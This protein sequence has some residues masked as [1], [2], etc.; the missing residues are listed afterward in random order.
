MRRTIFEANT[1]SAVQAKRVERL[2]EKAEKLRGLLNYASRAFVVEFA[3]TPKAGKST[4]VE[5]VSHL[6]RR[7]RFRV[8]VLRERAS[9][10]PIPMKGH[11]FFNTWWACTMLAELLENVEA[12]ADIVIKDRGLFDALVW[13]QLQQRR[14][15]VLPDEV[16]RIE[17]FLLLERWKN[18]ID[19]VVLFTV[20][21][22]SAI[23]R[24]IEP[25]I[26]SQVGSVMNPPMLASLNRAARD[27]RK[28]YAGYF[29]EFIPIDT[30]KSTARETGVVLA[31][32]IIDAL[33]RFVNPEILVI[34]RGVADTLSLDGGGCFNRAEVRKAV[35][36]IEANKRFVPRSD[37]ESDERLVQIIPASM[38]VYRGKVFTFQREETD[39]KYHLYGKATIWQGGHVARAKAGTAK[40]DYNS[41]LGDRLKEKL[42][43]S[44]RFD[45][46]IL[47]YA[48][49]RGTPQSS[50]H[51]GLIHRIDIND[52]AVAQD[53][54]NKAFR[55]GR[56]HDVIGKF[57]SPL[58][59]R[60]RTANGHDDLESWSQ[61]VL[62]NLASVNL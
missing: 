33:E 8:H 50:K 7:K 22:D 38:L 26:T 15:E 36:A 51:F 46:E 25:R 62:S 1:V 13:L 52:T 2:T 5:A 28:K 42:F 4:A 24:E 18:L 53:L 47:G 58:A 34:P 17:N 61:T 6:F 20:S 27:A 43:L 11:L 21:A 29:R 57:V 12:N 31:E 59:L 55:K 60:K 35:R 39:P 44:R 30:S 48:W 32:Q 40:V 3:G 16:R 56:G 23:R 19:V 37:A 10:C 45:T 41:I 49:D 14:G 9:F 54:E